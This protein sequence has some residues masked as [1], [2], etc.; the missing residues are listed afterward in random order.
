MAVGSS[1]GESVGLSVG[2]SVG[3]SVLLGSK[4]GDIAVRNKKKRA[5]G[6]MV[7]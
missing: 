7:R 1:E 4:E 6:K 2:V 3:I 5:T